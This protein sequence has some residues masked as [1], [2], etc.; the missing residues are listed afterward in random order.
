M[1]LYIRLAVIF[2]SIMQILCGC[3]SNNI[4][5]KDISNVKDG[6]VEVSLRHEIIKTSYDG[7]FQKE[8]EASKYEPVKGAYLGA[9]VLANPEI[10]FDI[11]KFEDA[12]GKNV[13]IGIRHYQL[14]DPFPDKWL[15]ECLAKKK[16]PHIVVTPKTMASPYDKEALEATALKFKNTYGIPAFIEFYPGPKE[17]GNPGE[18]ISYF[19]LA[20]EIFAQYAPNVAFVWSMDME[21]IYD[22]MIYYPGDD[23]VD[24]I[25][26]SMYFPI[27]KNH[28]KYN[29]DIGEKLDY[30]YNIYQDK[31]P[32]MISK[33]AVSHYSK[34]DHTFYINEARDIINHIYA[35]IPARYPRIKAINYIDLD[36]IKIAPNDTGYDNF[37]VSTEPKI[38]NMYKE[39]IKNPHY[40]DNVE[41]TKAREVTYWS[42]MKTPIYERDNNLY[43][44]EETITY[45]W[46]I[47]ITGKMK[48]SKVI[49]GGSEYYKLD[50]IA[51][52]AGYKINIGKDSVRIYKEISKR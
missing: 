46:G 19:R 52:A 39:A 33:L 13:A 31:K 34:E 25:G 42:K 5:N 2:F 16:A 50:Q 3:S 41:D 17:F 44:L 28:I 22:S 20:K 37:M 49:I 11:S 1:K 21:D 40:I 29:A 15:L 6:D 10:E 38:T 8:I 48:E 7:Y 14:G 24:W 43:V 27:Y 9:Y 32:M 4:L 45:D 51:K 23:Y 47:D 30:F 26:I 12:V 36:N 35:N 18:Y